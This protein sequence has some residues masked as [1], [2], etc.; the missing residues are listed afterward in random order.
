MPTDTTKSSRRQLLKTAFG[1]TAGMLVAPQLMAAL[2][3]KPERHLELFNLHT[4]E[5]LKTTYW[6]EGQYQAKEI[7]AINHILRDHRTNELFP[8]DRKL[9]DLM[10]LLLMPYGDTHPLEIISGYRS[11]STNEM[12]RK[13]GS[14]GV[15][16]KSYHTLGK[17]V[18]IKLAGTKLI[19][20]YEAAIELK[21][22]G[23]GYYPKDG[24]VHIDTGPV[25][26]WQG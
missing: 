20:L 14:G 17:A 19:D 2:P 16:K 11:E 23:V 5:Q 26:H 25:R 10:A 21:A 4:G 1:V 3:Q 7:K 12:L 6:V 18:D 8:I 9:I 15:A 13:T 24:F 22:G